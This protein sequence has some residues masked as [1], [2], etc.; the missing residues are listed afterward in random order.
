MAVAA[1]IAVLLGRYLIYVWYRDPAAT[2]PIGMWP[3]A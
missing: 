1:W 2:S 3:G